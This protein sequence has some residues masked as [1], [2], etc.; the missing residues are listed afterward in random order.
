MKIL[1]TGGR[2]FIGS[3]IYYQL[4]DFYQMEI[5]IYKKEKEDLEKC[6]TDTDLI[7]HFAG[8]NRSQNSEDF[9]LINFDLTKIICKICKKN[10]L[11]IPIIYS[12]TIRAEDDSVYG[13]S[14]LLAEKELIKYSKEMNAEVSILRLPNIFGKW[15]KP[16]YNSVVATFCNNIANNL[17]IKIH[18]NNT[19]L[20]LLYIDDLVSIVHDLI[21]KKLPYQQYPIINNNFHISL[22]DLAEMIYSFRNSRKNLNI[23]DY[24]KGLKKYLYSTYLTYLPKNK[25]SYSLKE[26]KDHRGIFSEIFKTD[27]SGQVSMFTINP[28]EIR[29]GHYHHTKTE[30]FLV[31]SGKAKFRSKNIINNEFVENIY[32]DKNLEIIETIPGWSHDIINIGNDITKILVWANEKFDINKPDTI[33]SEVNE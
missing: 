28:N 21:R 11:N 29:G 13:N 17:E 30:K 27:S 7:I 8:I 14:K 26:N 15:C 24:G 6:I 20:N 19:I 1:L 9:K 4:K 5:T 33:L 16:N 18:D 12:S 2:G 23:E 31:I 25:F 3:N 10:K 32:T 22:K